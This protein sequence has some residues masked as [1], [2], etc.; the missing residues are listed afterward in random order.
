M[1]ALMIAISL[2]LG[3]GKEQIGE[4]ASDVLGLGAVAVEP[5]YG[6]ALAADDAQHRAPDLGLVGSGDDD[7]L[8]PIGALRRHLVRSEA[9][10]VLG[11]RNGDR[12][13][14]FGDEAIA[15]DV[16]VAHD[17]PQGEDGDVFVALAAPRCRKDGDFAVAALHD[18]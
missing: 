4:A 10:L 13:P 3:I 7:D 6:S 2:L 14:G 15:L 11:P 1:F 16:V 8:D 9:A 18:E 5:D 12:H 17:A